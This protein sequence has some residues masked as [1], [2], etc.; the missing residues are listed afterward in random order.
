MVQKGFFLWYKFP[1]VVL[2]H[3]IRPNH[4][5]IADLALVEL[6]KSV[7]KM[8]KHDSWS[9]LS[10]SPV[11]RRSL[12]HVQEVQRGRLSSTFLWRRVF[13]WGII[14]QIPQS[15]TLEMIRGVS[16]CGDEGQQQCADSS[17]PPWIIRFSVCCWELGGVCSTDTRRTPFCSPRCF[18]LVPCPPPWLVSLPLCKY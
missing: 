16:S 3:C 15:Q 4:W 11:P 14:G 17:F 10:A 6:E 13:Q 5:D 18:S 1:F 7:I 2:S 12:H 9:S 8:A